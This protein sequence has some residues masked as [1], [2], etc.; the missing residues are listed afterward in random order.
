MGILKKITFIS[1]LACGHGNVVEIIMRAVRVVKRSFV[2]VFFYDQY[3]SAHVQIEFRNTVVVF[4]F[5]ES[6]LECNNWNQN[7]KPNV[8]C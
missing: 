4:N 6:T 8:Y 5:F 1:I 2:R 3:C 7:L